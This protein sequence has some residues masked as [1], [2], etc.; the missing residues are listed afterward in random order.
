MRQSD[1]PF[2]IGWAEADITP[3]E[4]VYIEG[5]FHA[6]M[7][8]EVLDPFTVTAWALQSGE[9]QAIFVSCEFNS[10][11]DE[12]LDAVRN[13]LN[14]QTNEIDPSKVVLHA[15]HTHTGPDIYLPFLTPR[16][17][18]ATMTTTGSG[19]E[20]PVTPIADYVAF[21]SKRIADV[22]VRA[23]NARAAGGIAFCCGIR[24]RC[25]QPVLG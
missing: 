19:V 6:R 21:A 24:G 20:L 14:A 10:I 3:Q 17:I 23:W 18:R 5:Q 16:R 22:I 15:T 13:N 2:L 4:P 1:A 12:L 9:D 11:S 25:P 8:E 7:S